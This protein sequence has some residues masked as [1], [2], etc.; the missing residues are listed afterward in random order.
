MPAT[1]QHP[2]TPAASDALFTS[3]EL[4]RCALPQ[5]EPVSRFEAARMRRRR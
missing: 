2:A 1:T 5:D 4:E 3:D